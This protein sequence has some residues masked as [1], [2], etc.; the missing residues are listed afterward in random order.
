ML[1]TRTEE[2]LKL[3]RE[4]LGNR[5]PLCGF[6]GYGELSPQQGNSTS[7]YRPSGGGGRRR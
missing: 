6:Y 4:A 2:E 7:S 1:G 5:V 3:I